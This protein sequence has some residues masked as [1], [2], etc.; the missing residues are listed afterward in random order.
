VS[1]WTKENLERVT[2][3]YLGEDD[4]SP[5]A[6]KR[7][8]IL[9]AATKLFMAQGYKK[10]SIDEVALAAHVAKGT[11]YLYYPSKADLLVHVI[12]LEKTALTHRFEPL[13]TG[14]IPPADRLRQY[15]H[16]LFASVTELPLTTKLMSGDAELLDALH[17]LGEDEMTKQRAQGRAW[18]EEL[19]ELAA[20]GRFTPEERRVRAEIVIGVQFTAVHLLSAHAR[21]DVAPDVFRRELAEVLASGL[22]PPRP[23]DREPAP[24]RRT[25]RAAKS[26]KKKR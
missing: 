8:R 2:R 1:H 7:A 14:A 15:L 25:A 6:K 4:G 20:P 13:L 12:A 10:T 23:R 22:A 17:E 21:G 5:Q 9:G 3:D 19:I 11:V 16:I 26:T 18:I 24:T